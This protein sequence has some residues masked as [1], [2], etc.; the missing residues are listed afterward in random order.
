MRHHKSHKSDSSRRTRLDVDFNPW[1]FV[2]LKS[3][4]ASMT[5]PCHS[6]VRTCGG[7]MCIYPDN[8]SVEAPGDT[9]QLPSPPR[10][11]CPT[12]RQ[13]IPRSALKEDGEEENLRTYKTPR[14]LPRTNK[15]P[16]S[17]FHSFLLSNWSSVQFFL[18]GGARSLF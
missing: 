9:P 16:I 2:I 8:L 7:P 14:T 6:Y 3:M 5:G 1:I 17:F 15:L 18:G 12:T 10:P 4:P 13:Q 11:W